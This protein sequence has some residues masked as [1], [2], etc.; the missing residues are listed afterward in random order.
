MGSANLARGKTSCLII[1]IMK[2]L[3]YEKGVVYRILNKNGV[4]D[5]IDREYEYMRRNT[6]FYSET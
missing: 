4:I 6:F 3:I 2:F 1:N 5:A